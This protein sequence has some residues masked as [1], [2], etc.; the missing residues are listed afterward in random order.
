ML[1]QGV[2]LK[3][4]AKY[5]FDSWIKKGQVERSRQKVRSFFF[6]VFSFIVRVVLFLR[7]NKCVRSEEECWQCSEVFIRRVS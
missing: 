2:I 7:R 4:D 5:L 3:S 6:S 1:G